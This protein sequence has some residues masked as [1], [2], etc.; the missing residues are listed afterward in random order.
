MSNIYKYD[1][2]YVIANGNMLAVNTAIHDMMR[3]L[4]SGIPWSQ[5]REVMPE[6]SS[7]QQTFS[8]TLQTS[9]GFNIK[10]SIR[11]PNEIGSQSV[12]NITLVSDNGTGISNFDSVSS[13]VT[14][15]STQVV[16]SLAVD[17]YYSSDNY[18][19]YFFGTTNLISSAF[20][21][22]KLKNKI[23]SET[24]DWLIIGSSNTPTNTYAATGAAYVYVYLNIT[25][26]TNHQIVYDPIINNVA[27]Q[28]AGTI[29]GIIGVGNQVAKLAEY[30]VND[31]L[32][33]ALNQKMLVPVT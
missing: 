28:L 1:H 24:A 31:Q 9:E 14:W 25:G 5:V 29:D 15:T 6:P 16:C 12:V 7:S 26:S 10:F 17:R 8:I 27:G 19:A 4:Q 33:I 30:N 18:N 32:Y 22:M 2:V 23:G 11:T 20:G 3:N 13:V 21:I